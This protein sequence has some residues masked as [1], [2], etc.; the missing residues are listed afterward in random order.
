[1]RDSH[2]S[3]LPKVFLLFFHTADTEFPHKKKICKLLTSIKNLM[4]E[5]FSK[6][7]LI[8]LLVSN[9]TLPQDHFIINN[10]VLASFMSQLTS[11][12]SKNNKSGIKRDK[13]IQ[14]TH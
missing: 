9:S 7:S 2:D 12:V 1:M 3:F 8:M 6:I 11:I 4:V 14:C 10:F 5:K 13:N